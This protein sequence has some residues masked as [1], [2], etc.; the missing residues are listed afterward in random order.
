MNLKELVYLHRD[1]SHLFCGY[2]I[3]HSL[4]PKD[5][6]MR[7]TEPLEALTQIPELGM[8]IAT[9]EPSPKRAM[10]LTEAALDT[11]VAPLLYGKKAEPQCSQCLE[12]F[13][14]AYYA[15]SFLKLP[16]NPR[17]RSD[18]LLGMFRPLYR[19][20]LREMEPEMRF[21]SGKDPAHW[22]NKVCQESELSPHAVSRYAFALAALNADSKFHAASYLMQKLIPSQI[23]TVKIVMQSQPP[24]SNPDYSNN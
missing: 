4:L 16:K 3:L 24:R 20:L 13:D 22:I 14:N 10:L 19:A 21:F 17:K 11:D 15:R 23:V 2:G 9:V 12:I 5:T 8:S 1:I 6:L 7:V 18:V